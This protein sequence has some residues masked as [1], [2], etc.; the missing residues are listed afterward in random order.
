MSESSTK[1]VIGVLVTLTVMFSDA[2]GW[3]SDE[4]KVLLHEWFAKIQMIDAFTQIALSNSLL[5]HLCLCNID[6]LLPL[7]L[8]ITMYSHLRHNSN[9][10]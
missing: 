4:F 10:K 5:Q 8:N 1:L 2:E 3:L 7:A 9:T 6:P